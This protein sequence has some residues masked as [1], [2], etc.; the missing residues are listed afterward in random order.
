MT[1]AELEGGFSQRN[2]S[3]SV[4][5]LQSNFHCFLFLQREMEKDCVW[6]VP[7]QC[8]ESDLPLTEVDSNR[9]YRYFCYPGGTLSVNVIYPCG[10]WIET[11]NKLIVDMFYIATLKCM[12]ALRVIHLSVWEVKVTFFPLLISPF[13]DSSLPFFF[14]PEANQMYLIE[15][16]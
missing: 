10:F 5:F 16:I 2:P 9:T 11:V 3:G 7:S 14:F 6:L 15:L 12:Q 8:E 1:A 13:R 4:P